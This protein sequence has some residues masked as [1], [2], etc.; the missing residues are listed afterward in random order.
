MHGDWVSFI[1]SDDWLEDTMYEKM[2]TLAKKSQ[3]DIVECEVYDEKES[4]TGLRNIWGM[5][6]ENEAVHEGS[7]RWLFGLAYTPALW[8]KLIKTELICGTQFSENC[9]YGED[10][11]FLT[12]AMRNA[13]RI[14]CSSVYLYHY[15]SER[16]GNVFSASISD[17]IFDFL[18]S[19]GEICETL[20]QI[21][22]DEAAGQ[23]VYTTA[24]QV[25]SKLSLKGDMSRYCKEL[26]RFINKYNAQFRLIY[27]NYRRS[28]LRIILVKI[29]R[30]SPMLSAALWNGKEVLKGR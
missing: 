17:K 19:Y 10:A 13:K 15:R 1:D 4:G 22:Q 20:V 21:G 28:R 8:N 30:L 12:E 29:A 7:A 24:V 5:S 18:Q 26:K 16:A 11:L 9:R 6:D 14:S 3:S 23:L 27:P 2:I 25:I